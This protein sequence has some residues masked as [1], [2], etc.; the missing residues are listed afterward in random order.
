MFYNRGLGA[1]L[2]VV[3]VCGGR[4]GWVA[5]HQRGLVSHCSVKINDIPVP[6]KEQNSM[7]YRWQQT[8]PMAGETHVGSQDYLSV[9]AH[10]RC[11]GRCRWMYAV[12]GHG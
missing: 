4:L 5:F 11:L 8:G 12:P 1:W 3:I 2:W 6:S 9:L 7:I 10:C